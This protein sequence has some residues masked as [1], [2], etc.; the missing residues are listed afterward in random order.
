MSYG[1]RSP[2]SFG[3]EALHSLVAPSLLVEARRGLT[4]F[5]CFSVLGILCIVFLYTSLVYV[6]LLMSIDVV[7]VKGSYIPVR[8]R[9][10]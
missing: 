7:V 1:S 8:G 3:L 6:Y 10:R 2:S 9:N 4:F 5:P